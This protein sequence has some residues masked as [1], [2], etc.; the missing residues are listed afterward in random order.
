MEWLSIGVTDEVYGLF[1]YPHFSLLQQGK[2][3][4]RGGEVSY[5]HF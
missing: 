4:G 1:A 3:E 5:P 2:G